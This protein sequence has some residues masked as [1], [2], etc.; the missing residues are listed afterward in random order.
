MIRRGGEKKEDENSMLH[1]FP[2]NSRGSADIKS[3]MKEGLLGWKGR[4]EIWFSQ[5]SGFEM[6]PQYLIWRKN[7]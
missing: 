4:G 3:G 1:G 7:I 5:F 2:Q 6:D